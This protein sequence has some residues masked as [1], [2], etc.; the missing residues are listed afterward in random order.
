VGR[1]IITARVRKI[2]YMLKFALG[3]SIDDVYRTG[4]EMSAQRDSS[5]LI[6][7]LS[8]LDSIPEP[9]INC[10]IGVSQ[11]GHCNTKRA[12]PRMDVKPGVLSVGISLC[13]FLPKSAPVICQA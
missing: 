13:K 4:L 10:R 5:T 1:I 7:E 9:S 6:F 8:C 3:A 12:V 11:G 2:K